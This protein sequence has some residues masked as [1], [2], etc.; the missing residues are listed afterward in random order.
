MFI[1]HSCS[2]LKQ[3]KYNVIN[4]VLIDKEF[5]AILN[6]SFSF[7]DYNEKNIVL[8]R[9][10]LYPVNTLSD[11]TFNWD[12]QMDTLHKEYRS[13]FRIEWINKE[14][15]IVLDQPDIAYI[16]KQIANN[17]SFSYWQQSKIK[18]KNRFIVIDSDSLHNNKCPYNSVNYKKNILVYHFTEP[19]FNKKRTIAVFGF[20]CYTNSSKYDTSFFRGMAIMK[21]ENNQWIYLGCLQGTEVD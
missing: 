4:D 7:S 15:K 18:N 3:E 19:I 11:Y 14:K 17:H 2:S 5:N 1:T 20:H 9:K 13:Q 6:K 10:D 21:K 8:I 16:R 12:I